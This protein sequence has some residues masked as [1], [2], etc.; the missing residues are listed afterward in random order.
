MAY[1]QPDRAASSDDATQKELKGAISMVRASLLKVVDATQKELKERSSGISE[2]VG[3]TGCNSERI[4]RYYQVRQLPQR[5][6][7]AQMQL[8]KN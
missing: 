1:Q 6:A 3:N 2:R 4:E 7:D 5:A 8:R